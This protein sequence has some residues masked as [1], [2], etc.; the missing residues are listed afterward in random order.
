MAYPASLSV[1]TPERVANW[2][3]LLQWLLALPHW[4]IV[5]VLGYVSQAIAFI[6]WFAILFTGRLPAGLANFQIMY[7]RYNARLYAYAGFLYSRYPPFAFDMTADDPGGAPVSVSVQ[8]Q[9]EGRNRLTT[10][11]RLILAIPAGLFALIVGIIALV[12][13]LLGVLAVLFTGRWPSGLRGWVVSV[14]GVDLRLNVYW[15][16]LTDEYPPFSLDA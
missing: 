11:V 1:E 7:L 8:P 4:I 5:T 14:M 15:S 12:C 9:L 13:H 2:R 16:L 6:S 10:L 3:P